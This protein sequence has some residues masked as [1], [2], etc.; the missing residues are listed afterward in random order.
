MIY[1]LS[2]GRSLMASFRDIHS[3]FE[4]HTIVGKSIAD[5]RPYRLDYRIANI[6]DI[7]DPES[8]KIPSG[9]TTDGQICIIFDDGDHIEIE[10]PGCAPIILGFNTADFSQYP[11]YDGSCYTLRTMFQKCL[12]HRITKVA[13]E[14]TAGKMLFPKYRGID[15]SDDDDGIYEIRLV[16][17]DGSC[18]CAHGWLDFFDILHYAPNGDDICVPFSELLAELDE[19]YK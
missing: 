10:I 2:D 7:E 15:M 11:E 12:G 6:E 18:L 17:D 3:Y 9:I 16:L 19:E 8:A 14:K 4:K 13:F 5:I 1:T